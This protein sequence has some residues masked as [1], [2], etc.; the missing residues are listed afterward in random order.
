MQ[1]ELNEQKEKL[2]KAKV[3][4]AELRSSAVGSNL[5]AQELTALEQRYIVDLIMR[6]K[7]LRL[8]S[9][10]MEYILKNYED[11]R[12]KVVEKIAVEKDV[13]VNGGMC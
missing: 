11:K 12:R 10:K 9:E 6:N 13:L 4:Y 3:H 1:R 7:V 2:E 8:D 5:H